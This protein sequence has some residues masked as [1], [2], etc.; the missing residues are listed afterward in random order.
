MERDHGNSII[1]IFVTNIDS[2]VKANRVINEIKR[3]KK[4]QDV[5]IDYQDCDHVMRVKFL[6]MVPRDIINTVEGFGYFC[7]VMPG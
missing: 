2:Q 3:N 5:T 1:E 7:Y 4:V 6:E